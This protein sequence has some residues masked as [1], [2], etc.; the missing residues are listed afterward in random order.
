MGNYDETEEHGAKGSYRVQSKSWHS[1]AVDRQ[2][3]SLRDDDD[4]GS[5]RRVIDPMIVENPNNPNATVKITL[6]AQRRGKAD[7][8]WED[9]PFLLSAMQA[10]EEVRIELNSAET[11]ALYQ[12]LTR[13]YEVGKEGVRMGDNLMTV[14]NRD[15]VALISGQ[16]KAIVES[17][18]ESQGEGILEL[19][20]SIQPD[21]L[22]AAALAKR[23]TKWSAALAEFEEHVAAEDWD[24]RRWQKFFEDNPWVF[25]HGLDYRF[26]VTAK[27]QPNY[28]GT[29]VTGRGGE[30]GDFLMATEG[31][32]R[33][34]VL[35]E[36]KRPDTDLLGNAQYRNGAWQIGEELAGGV[37]QLQANCNRWE[38]EGSRTDANREWQ[39]EEGIAT[40][41]PKGILL[42]GNTERLDST[43]KTET[44][45]RFRRN[46]WNPQ[47]LTYDELLDRTRFLVRQAKP[48][49]VAP[50]QADDDD[51]M[52]AW[53]R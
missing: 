11:L 6:H 19:I 29:A 37:A 33:F 4:G 49:G 24:E 2:V 20:D 5:T 21:L 40:V 53:L 23:Y 14:F 15:D 35:V 47:V 38:K 3:L 16:A 28:G 41:Q 17:L 22:T 52:P 1:A 51:E 18:I 13:L 46:L 50:E 44:F 12:H 7:G 8:P 31:D 26:L 39:N 32:V 10:G 27:A 36:I 34:A 45:E 48:E 9:K 25:G 30:K 43:A 42:I